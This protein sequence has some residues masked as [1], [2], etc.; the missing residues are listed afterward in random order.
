MR[1]YQAALSGHRHT[2]YKVTNPIGAQKCIT[3][4]ACQSFENQCLANSYCE[5]QL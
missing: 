4:C 3:Y 2:H 5:R 1:L